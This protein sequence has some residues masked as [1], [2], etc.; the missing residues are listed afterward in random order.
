MDSNDVVNFGIDEA[1]VGIIQPMIKQ[2][3]VDWDPLTDATA[4]G[5]TTFLRPWT[6]ILR[7]HTSYHQETEIK[8]ESSLFHIHSMLI[9]PHPTILIHRSTPYE[10]LLYHGVLPKIRSA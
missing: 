9:T 3:L 6:S 10:S 5:L 8:A 7:I 1:V 4:S 2:S